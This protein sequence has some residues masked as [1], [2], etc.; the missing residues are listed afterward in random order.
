MNIDYSSQHESARQVSGEWQ[1][2]V[3]GNGQQ[4]AKPAHEVESPVRF[5]EVMRLCAAWRFRIRQYFT[6]SETER[7]EGQV[8]WFS[9]TTIRVNSSG[10]RIGVEPSIPPYI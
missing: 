3:G 10:L 6:L 4:I 8:R 1:G 7:T 2:A 9:V 5:M